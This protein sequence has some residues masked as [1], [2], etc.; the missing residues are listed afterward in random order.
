MSKQSQTKMQ[1][2][3]T[4]F[5]TALMFYTRIPSPIKL[6]YSA[7]LLNKSRKYF[8][9]IGVLIGLIAS[10]V[11]VLSS[12][13]LPNTIAI[14][15]SMIASILATGAFHEDGFA[16]ACDGFGGGWQKDQVLTIMKDSRLGTYGALG[17]LLILVCKFLVLISLSE[18][19][20]NGVFC[21]AYIVAHTLSRQLSSSA[22]EL[23]DYVQDIDQS[24]V[25]PITELRLDK[26][27]QAFSWMITV[28]LT[29]C[30]LFQTH[31]MLAVLVSAAMAGIWLTYSK[32]RI[33]GYTG[34]V[35][36]ATQQLSEVMFYL[37][38][39]ISVIP[40]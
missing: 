7:A 3:W 13:V 21:L 14:L 6:E 24:K 25:K 39:L 5:L 40:Q 35:L 10:T 36:G 26:S 27:S 20:S 9:L 8:S 37:V 17:L 33:G 2:E 4:L 23:F 11:Y 30:L 31:A 15:L 19:L 34:D 32:K 12:S 18:S 38:L 1:Y 29:L 28:L 16:D 22:I